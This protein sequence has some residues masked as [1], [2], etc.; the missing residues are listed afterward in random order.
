MSLHSHKHSKKG[1]TLVE[2]VVAMTLTAI[3]AVACIALI[4]PIESIY[5]RTEKTVRAQLL[6]DTIVDSI[7]KECDD[8]QYDEEYSV[9]IASGSFD[10]SSEDDNK[11]FTKG[12][13]LN[14]GDPGQILVIK[15]NNNYCEAIYSCLNISDKNVQ[16]VK[17]NVKTG[18]STGHAVS[19][20]AANLENRKA[21][22]VHY[23]YY[24]A[25][26]SNMGLYPFA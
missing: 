7:R 20:I 26:D 11:L 21:G 13:D 24:Q 6:A 3:F 22:I 8:V 19:S 5:Q 18:T 1:T 17:D 14:T 9:W 16:A 23:G 15:R 4:Q 25:K 10:V 2:L 12:V